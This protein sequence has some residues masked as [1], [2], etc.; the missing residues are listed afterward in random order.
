MDAEELFFKYA[1][2][3]TQA[4][5]D[6]K[7]IDKERLD[8]IEG[9]FERKDV[10]SRELLE[11]TYKEA[12]RRINEFSDVVWDIDVIKRYFLE[13]HNRFIDKGDGFYK[14]APEY[15]RELC[16]VHIGAVLEVFDDHV[17]IEYEGKKKKVI[18]IYDL[19]ICK[20]DTVSVHYFIIIEKL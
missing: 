2:P 11:D 12:I 10:P 4:L 7:N 18:N 17:E 5:Y 9:F 3:C 13:E 1:Y 16:K 8:E 14:D 19:S 20:G 15:F 6:F